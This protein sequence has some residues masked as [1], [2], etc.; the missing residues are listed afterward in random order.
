MARKSGRSTGK[1]AG[2][3]AL[4]SGAGALLTGLIA[5]A[6]ALFKGQVTA[7]VVPVL[8]GAGSAIAGWI[9]GS[10]IGARLTD[11]G[12]AVSKLGRGGTEV[13]VRAGGRDE[14]GALGRSLQYLA[15]DLTELQKQQE[16]AGG[17]LATM[18]PQV[19]QL[20]DRTLP[21][22]LPQYAGFEIDGALCAG[23]R[24]GLDYYDA[25][26]VE[27]T[28]VLYLVSAE[29]FGA[30]AVVACRMARDELHRALAQGAAPRK[31]LSHANRVLKQHLPPGACAKASVLQLS[32][33]GA[34]LYQAGARAPLLVCQRGEVRE[35]AAEGLALGLDD[36][37]V[38]DKA[39]RP[40]EV[41]T[42]PGVRMLLANEAALRT[43]DFRARIAQYSPKHTAMFMNMVLG[44]IEEDAGGDGLREDVV[45]ISAKRTGAT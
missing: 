27:E 8:F 11:L 12:L 3:F 18:D 35:V 37:P 2:R 42:T 1:L 20:R 7:F 34:K 23:S 6:D 28:A 40:Q 21:Q 43:D 19:R 15:N 38:F 17:A 10:R 30:V 24:G 39:L 14:I 32:A 13:K 36:G 5:S 26:V 9:V 4:T 45:L 29:G 16:K 25:A 44:G 41:A 22:S 33:D 31:A